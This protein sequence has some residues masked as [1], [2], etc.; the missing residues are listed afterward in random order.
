MY[1]EETQF[2]FCKNY[3]NGFGTAPGLCS[4]ALSSFCFPPRKTNSNISNTS[5]LSQCPFQLQLPLFY[6]VHTNLLCFVYLIFWDGISLCSP[7]YTRAGSVHQTDLQLR[8][9]PASGSQVWGIKACGTTTQSPSKQKLKKKTKQHMIFFNT[10][11][12]LDAS[13]SQ[14]LTM[15][16]R[17]M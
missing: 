13:F 7:G 16:F 8:E 4:L 9:Q 1:N 5:W 6:W 2:S 10:P 14:K 11:L 3:H 17:G 15:F 12:V